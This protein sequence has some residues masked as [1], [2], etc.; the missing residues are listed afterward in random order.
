MKYVWLVEDWSCHYADSPEYHCVCC[1]RKQAEDECIRLNGLAYRKQLNRW[2]EWY[3]DPENPEYNFSRPIH[4]DD[5]DTTDYFFAV[6]VKFT[7]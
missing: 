4:P 5:C 3:E 7:G 1:T 2:R 6:K